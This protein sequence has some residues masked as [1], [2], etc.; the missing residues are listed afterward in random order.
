[1]RVLKSISLL[2]CALFFSSGAVFA[3]DKY[4]IEVDAT[5]KVI[6][7]DQLHLPGSTPL[8]DVLALIPELL[9]SSDLSVYYGQFDIQIE[10]ISV[11]CAANSIVEHMHLSDLKSISIS[12]SPS[13]SQQKNSSGGVINLSLN[14]APDG[15]SGRAS[16]NLSTASQYQPSAM[17]N[18]HKDKLT[19]RSW[20]MF[21]ANT[22]G[23]KNEYRTMLTDH[24][25]IYAIDTTGTR[26]ISQMARV[27]ADYSPTSRDAFQFR[28]WE[29]SSSSD[30]FKYMQMV[31]T[32]E[33]DSG[34]SNANKSFNISAT[35]AYTHK[36]SNDHKAKVELGYLY[37][38]QSGNDKRRNTL[39]VGGSPNRMV[40]TLS[41]AHQMDGKLS[42]SL[43]LIKSGDDVRLE[44]RTGTNMTYK[45][46]GN[47]FSEKVN[48]AGGLMAPSHLDGDIVM[49]FPET[50]FFISPYVEF[51]GGWT[52]FKYK[53]NLKYQ[54]FESTY[55]LEGEE[56][57][58][59]TRSNDLT[60]NLNFG[61]Q[62]TPHQHLRL[63]FDRSVIRPSGWQMVPVLV[64]R[65]DKGSYVIGNPELHSSRLNSV[66]LDY[67]TDLH[68]N[69]SDMIINGSLGLIH[70]DGLI[71]TVHDVIGMGSLLPFITY[72]NAGSSNILKANL[73]FNIMNGPLMMSLSSNFFTKLQKA[74]ENQDYNIY[75]NC[76]LG[77]VYRISRDWTLASELA[78]NSPVYQPSVE[79]S[80]ALNGSLRISKVWDKLESYAVVTNILHKA[81]WEVTKSSELTTYRYYDLYASSIILGFSYHF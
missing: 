25:T 66:N 53:L 54:H 29:S 6:N 77:A 61:W 36:F 63:V 11:D 3:Q 10:G 78:Y 56:G 19:V 27:Y 48:L 68:A 52:K 76:S 14:D 55:G 44:M 50:S 33:N 58:E 31:P 60:G 59:S 51:G 9:N 40:Q 71:S 65:P 35:A 26:D 16:V 72:E 41:R 15:F 7:V 70:T 18:Y 81:R 32:G 67:I 42:Y 79:H 43:P 34:G 30:N 75:Y 73:L 2:F 12:E 5:D 80:P 37:M 69:N 46:A 49:K 64:Y 17:L 8:S 13:A 62:M 45:T 39:V 4:V 23:Q 57:E 74:G 24:G 1:M 21:D 22:P 38:P 20:L 47:E 28:V